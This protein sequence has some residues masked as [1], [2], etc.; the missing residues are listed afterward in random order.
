MSLWKERTVF[1]R[2]LLLLGLI[3]TA[4]LLN[5]RVGSQYASHVSCAFS[6]KYLALLAQASGMTEEDW[7][8]RVSPAGLGYVIHD[9]WVWDVDGRR[10]YAIADESGRLD[11]SVERNTRHAF[12]EPESS[13]T[14]IPV[15]IEDHTRTTMHL[16]AEMDPGFYRGWVVKALW[17]FPDYASRAMGND[18]REIENLLFRAVTDRGLRLLIL[19]PFTNQAGELLSDPDIYASCLSSLGER[20]ERRGILLGGSVDPL[21]PVYN[22]NYKMILAALLPCAAGVWFLMLL[23]PVKK[24]SAKKRR[25]LEIA[26][27]IL[28][29]LAA[30]F[31]VLVLPDMG[32][33]LLPLAAAIL[34]PCGGMFAIWQW[35][36]REPNIFAKAPFAVSALA[37]FGLW[38]GWSLLCGLTVGALMTTPRYLMGIAVFSG[39]KFAL[40][41]PLILCFGLLFS[42]FWRDF[43]QAGKKVWGWLTL[44]ALA[45]MA[46]L[47]VVRSGDLPG[48]I[49]GVE[50]A[51]RNFL[52]DFFYGRPR[53]KELLFAAPCVPVFVWACRKKRPSLQL[54]CGMGAGLE[55]VSVVNT[56]C[57]GVASVSFS[58]IRSVEGG[59]AGWCLGMLAVGILSLLLRKTPSGQSGRR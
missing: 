7:L 36:R 19:S 45:G 11:P 14:V 49:S 12:W 35:A 53:T 28:V 24:L 1:W 27:I 56:F 25:Q 50:T 23:P 51:L 54:L 22:Q 29:V 46:L 15:A 44:A 17:L 48:G 40:G 42:L 30:I 39:V 47:L 16:P 9:R 3:G 8:A 26:A 18:T 2:V 59:L 4:L 33:K 43:W 32:E 57:H 38:M 5:Q 58:V 10:C 37:A 55:C 41:L 21:R 34:L 20:L 52:E 13:M 6:Q 31:L